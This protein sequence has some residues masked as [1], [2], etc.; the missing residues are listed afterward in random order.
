MT[1]TH[2]H[3]P[4]YECYQQN[5]GEVFAK[6]QTMKAHMEEAH[7]EQ[8]SSGHSTQCCFEDCEERFLDQSALFNHQRAEHH[9]HT[10]PHQ[11]CS[12]AFRTQN[13]LQRHLL[14]IHNGKDFPCPWPGCGKVLGSESAHKNVVFKCAYPSCKMTF[15]TK[16]CLSNHID[17]K[18]PGMKT[19]NNPCPAAELES[20]H[21]MF[22]S[23]RKASKHANM[24]HRGKIPCLHREEFSCNVLFEDTLEARLHA[25]NVHSRYMCNVQGQGCMSTIMG[26]VFSKRG[27]RRSHV[28]IHMRDP[29]IS[30]DSLPE[31]QLKIVSGTIGMDE[32]DSNVAED[33]LDHGDPGSDY[34]AHSINKFFPFAHIADDIKHIEAYSISVQ[35]RNEQLI[36]EFPQATRNNKF[37]GLKC[38]GPSPIVN[39]IVTTICPNGTT[40][41]YKTARI[42]IE[43]QGQIIRL[44]LRCI[45]CQTSYT[46]QYLIEKHML[47]E[48]SETQICSGNSCFQPSFRQ[49]RL[50]QY[51]LSSWT[52]SSTDHPDYTNLIAPALAITWVADEP[53]RCI[54][55]LLLSI[56]AGRTDE[57]ELRFLDLEFNSSTKRVFEIGMCDFK[58]NITLDCRTRYQLETY[59]AT[60]T[61]R[62][63]ADAYMD[64]MIER[65]TARHY[66]KDSRMSAR[67]VADRLREQ[68]VSPKTWFVTWHLS[69]IDLSVLRGWLESEGQFN[70]LPDNSRCL[71]ILSYFRSN[72]KAAPR[73]DGRTLP[74]ALGILF[75]LFMSSQHELA[76]KNHHAAVDAQQAYYLTE[77]YLMQHRCPAD[78]PEGWLKRLQKPRGSLGRQQQRQQTIES[79]WQKAKRYLLY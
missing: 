75:P 15:T 39:K 71:P 11:D 17:R 38:A 9:T 50:C 30:C 8:Q 79:L 51:H 26:H 73:I 35:Q 29:N 45:E 7:S 42:K 31:P 13:N 19:Y 20:C 4:S 12:K 41:D 22:S 25:R 72:L 14:R 40:L 61:G 64:L 78:R 43:G 47:L 24:T 49:S 3:E 77:V 5:C 63:R 76:G 60:T 55:D 10:C 48:E 44:P 33:D 68:G 58:G 70:V 2:P 65:S 37:F 23:P 34:T 32:M 62:G 52:A 56:Q 46:F 74:G 6:F 67:Q 27:Y 69:P 36:R 16:H 66:C 59:I 53:V 28:K 57:S 54:F 21:H 18:H 1:K